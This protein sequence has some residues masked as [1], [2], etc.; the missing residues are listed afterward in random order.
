MP[1]PMP[2]S[3]ICSPSHM[4]NM[5]PV[6]SVSTHISGSPSP[7]CRSAAGRRPPPSA[8]ARRR[9]RIACTSAS[10]QREVARDWVILRRPSSPSFEMR[11]RYGHTTVSSCRMIDELMYGI[12]PEGEDRHPREVAAREHVVQAEHRVPRRLR[13][14][15]SAPRCSPRASGCGCRCGRRPS[16]ASVNST[17]LRRSVMAKR[18]FSGLSIGS[19]PV[20]LC[21]G[22]LAPSYRPRVPRPPRR[23][24]RSSQRPCR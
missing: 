5:V 16:N 19:S 15:R 4:M 18:F 7:G 21:A 13:H 14:H 8:R 23:R 1:L 17:R 22:P 2:R 12:T 20:R 3:V 10:S 24:P 6:M 11:S 9:C